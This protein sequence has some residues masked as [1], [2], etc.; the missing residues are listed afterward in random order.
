MRDIQLV[1]L[2]K[3][4]EN[5]YEVIPEP[6]DDPGHLEGK[7]VL[8]QEV[9]KRIL[10]LMGSN[11]INPDLGS[12]FPRVIA[13]TSDLQVNIAFSM[14]EDQ[15]KLDQ[16]DID[17]PDEEKLDRIL[18][19]DLNVHPDLGTVEVLIRVINVQGDW[20]GFMIRSPGE[21]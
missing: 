5:L 14:L 15:I 1:T 4:Q 7:E 11:A 6:P 10:T 19:D 18:L 12:L 2:S 21:E 13:E 3:I 20:V 16:E 17:I 8:A 9:V